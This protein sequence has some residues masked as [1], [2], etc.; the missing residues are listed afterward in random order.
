MM[1]L[2]I[3]RMN[4]MQVECRIDDSFVCFSCHGKSLVLLLEWVNLLFVMSA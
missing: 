2:S 4:D 3:H 1:D